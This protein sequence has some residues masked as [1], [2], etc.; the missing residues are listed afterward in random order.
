M[1]GFSITAD[2]CR[3]LD[4]EYEINDILVYLRKAAGMVGGNTTIDEAYKQLR[5]KTRFADEDEKIMAKGLA[6]TAA[7]AAMM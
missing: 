6:L 1:A 3:K 2:E 5:A 4:E 7:Q